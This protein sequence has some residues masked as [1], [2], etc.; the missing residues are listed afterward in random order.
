MQNPRTS[1]KAPD[2][3]AFTSVARV[4]YPSPYT[5]EKMISS[6]YTNR[7]VL[8]AVSIKELIF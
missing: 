2:F 7:C 8:Q 6:K 1:K 3:L 4:F 5:I